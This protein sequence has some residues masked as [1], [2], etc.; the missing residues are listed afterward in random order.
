MVNKS[1]RIILESEN[2]EKLKELELKFYVMCKTLGGKVIDNKTGGELEIPDKE[3]VD[4][5]IDV[6]QGKE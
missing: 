4:E 5:F 1:Y 2:D 3:K 6:M